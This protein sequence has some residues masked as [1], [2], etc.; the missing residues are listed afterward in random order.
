MNRKSFILVLVLVLAMSM[1]TVFA[2]GDIALRIDSTEVEFNDDLGRPFMDENHR[3]LV[4]FRAA[5]ESYGA[6]VE[7]DGTT[8]TA[9]A[10][11]D[12]ITIE[13]P[14]GENYIVKNGE[15]IESDTAAIIKD[16]RTYLPIRKVMEGFGADVQWDK[17]LQTIVVTTEPFDAKAK[18]IE[19]YDKSSTW[20]NFDMHML[21]DMSITMPGE[22]GQLESM[23]MKMDMIT[24]AFMNP[25]KLRQAGNMIM[26]LDGEEMSQ[27]MP[28]I[29]MV[30]DGDKL[31][32]YTNMGPLLTEE[33]I[34]VK[35]VME[36]EGLGGLLA[37]NS[38]VAK[39]INEKSIKNV[40][41][42]GTYIEE[43]RSLEKY[44]ITITFE[45]FNELM[46]DLMSNITGS[47]ANDELAMGLDI[48]ENLDDMTYVLYVDQ[49]SGEQVKMEMD[50][51]SMIESMFEELINIGM[52]ETEPPEGLT[53]EELEELAEFEEEFRKIMENM[54]ME[55]DLVGEYLNVNN[56]EDFEIPK[57]ALNA[58]TMDE[59]MEMIEEMFGD[60][61]LEDLEGIE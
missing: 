58:I 2:Q 36:A 45:G 34:W 47:L 10:V 57:E 26:Y 30:A 19:A 32:S 56:A 13:I 39:E 11:K 23:D 46:G 29:Y 50:L 31:I 49:V 5:L 6:D 21:M 60:I 16:N 41:Y 8:R 44:E 4:P 12:D 18:V 61:D 54:T 43:D 27:P 35:E 53:E 20:E 28:A 14:I 37:P 33:E 25:I 7:W 40:N 17:S 1:S 15:K 48:I 24:T 59:Y 52:G 51:T 38:E 55:V 22:E 3:T 42:L 9:K